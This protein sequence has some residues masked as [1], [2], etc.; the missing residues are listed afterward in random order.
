MRQMLKRA[1]L[2]LVV[3]AAL[4]GMSGCATYWRSRG[5]DF[6]DM[7]DIGIT[8]SKKQQF[9]LYSSFES[10][11]ALGY[12]DFE[13]T[14]AG[15]GGGRFGVTHHSVKA[16]GVVVWAHE[17]LGWGDFDRNDPNT[18]YVQTTGLV[19]MPYGLIEGPSNPNYVPT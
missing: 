4:I 18:L 15:W 8:L 14:F 9:V 17:E 12:G 5:D 16:W 1:V 11:L 10:V 7:L 2:L 3:A 13:G 6:A 19:G